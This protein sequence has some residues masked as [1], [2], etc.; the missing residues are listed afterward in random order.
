MWTEN[1]PTT[2]S[3]R[4]VFMAPRSEWALTIYILNWP[5]GGPSPF[6]NH[7]RIV[8]DFLNQSKMKE[9]AEFEIAG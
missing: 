3:D 6:Q 2:A 9:R 4:K 1:N 8:C 7:D 5:R